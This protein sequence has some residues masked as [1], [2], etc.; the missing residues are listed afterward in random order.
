M[1]KKMTR[2]LA[3]LM[4]AAPLSCN[5]NLYSYFQS[6][7]DIDSI[8]NRVQAELDAQDW[9]NAIVDITPLFI[10]TPTYGRV[11]EYY[12]SGYA[13]RAGFI[14]MAAILTYMQNLQTYAGGAQLIKTLLEDNSFMD[15]PLPGN[16]VDIDAAY[17]ALRDEAAAATSRTENTNMFLAFVSLARAHMYS[18]LY[19]DTDNNEALDV[20]FDAC[21]PARL[22]SAIADKIMGSIATFFKSVAET[23]AGTIGGL[24][25]YAGVNTV[26]TTLMGPSAANVTGVWTET[27]NA[28][29]TNAASND[30]KA[31]RSVLGGYNNVAAGIPNTLTLGIDNQGAAGMGRC[32]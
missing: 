8:L 6:G 1:K 20:G 10:L 7:N 17:D 16:S 5:M 23:S 21:N 31:L 12:A 13:G 18:K 29:V 26:A 11:R 3:V 27:A 22:P 24:A 2:L 4:I 32:P 28:C 19:A 15:T 14:Y 30:C 9:T 25:V